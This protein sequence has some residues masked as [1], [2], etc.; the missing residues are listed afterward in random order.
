MKRILLGT[1]VLLALPAQATTPSAHHLFKGILTLSPALVERELERGIDMSLRY[2]QYEDTPLML[3]LRIYGRMLRTKATA[4]QIT[5]QSWGRRAMGALGLG[6]LCGYAY[7]YKKDNILHS[8]VIAGTVTT[9]TMFATALLSQTN[10]K[11]IIKMLIEADPDINA[12]NKEGLSALDILRA[13]F[14]YAY[15]LNDPDWHEL[16]ALIVQKSLSSPT[17]IVLQTEDDT[18]DNDNE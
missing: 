18:A 10:I 12:R 16:F 17:T 14:P 9:A 13:Y 4:P 1:T 2:G 8:L 6:A 5:L 3:A 15:Q 7:Y 11:K